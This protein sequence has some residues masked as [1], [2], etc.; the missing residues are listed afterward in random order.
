MAHREPTDS[1]QT[2]LTRDRARI[3]LP[4]S[5][6]SSY[7]TRSKCGLQRHLLENRH[8]HET[9]AKTDIHTLGAVATR[10]TAMAAGRHTR[11]FQVSIS[12]NGKIVEITEIV[13][14]TA[15]MGPAR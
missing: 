3:I 11:M 9:R 10:F 4:R 1:E 6:Y 15:E 8:Q 5:E 7:S 2:N 12:I 13:V 14:K